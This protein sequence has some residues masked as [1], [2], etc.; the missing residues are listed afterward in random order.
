M[1]LSYPAIPK[2]LSIFALIGFV[3]CQKESFKNKSFL[4]LCI[5]LLFSGL[6]DIFLTFNSQ[7]DFLKGLCLFLCAHVFFILT[8]MG[9]IQK[10]LNLNHLQKVQKIIFFVPILCGGGFLL[11]LVLGD[12]L[13]PILKFPTF[14]YIFTINILILTAIFSRPFPSFIF[15]GTICF[16]LSDILLG[17]SQFVFSSQSHQYFVWGFY[18]AAQCLIVF[19]LKFRRSLPIRRLPV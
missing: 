17:I 12:Y 15:L 2:S 1:S 4:F 16:G 14:L 10:P 3:V 18:Y 7:T 8:F 13:P 11:I 5:A 6:G 9:Y 19:G